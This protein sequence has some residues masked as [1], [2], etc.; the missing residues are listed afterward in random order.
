MAAAPHPRLEVL[1][2]SKTFDSVRVLRDVHIEIAPGEIHGLAGHNGSGKSTLV[3][4]LAG[5]HAPDAG[6]RVRLDGQ[7]LHLP[8]SPAQARAA[9]LGIVH[10]DL[11]LLDE[12]SIADNVCVGGFPVRRWTRRI[13]RGARDRLTEQALAF[14]G[15]P[16]GPS[17][18]VASLPAAHRAA[19]ATARAVRHHRPGSGMLVLD[20]STRTATGP[21]RTHIHAF[22]RRIA[23]EG[24]AVLLVSHSLPELLGTADRVTVL[25]D[26]QVVGAGL[27]TAGLTETQLARLMLG[28]RPVPPTG[29]PARSLPSS[30]DRAPKIR[31]SSLD[32]GRVSGISLTVHR[33]EIVGICGVPG[34]GFEDLPRL[35]AGALPARSGELVI[36]QRRLDLARADVRTCLRAGVALV[37]ECRDRE[38]LAYDVDVLNNICLPSLHSRGRPGILRRMRQRDLCAD[39]LQGFD[40]RPA[41]PERHNVGILSGGNQQKVLLAKWLSAT[42]ELLILHEPTQSVD[43]G[44]RSDILRAI[45]IAAAAS[46]SVLVVSSEPETLAAVCDRV[47]V[48]RP[49]DGRLVQL[50]SPQDAEVILEQLYTTGS[51]AHKAT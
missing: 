11:G 24:S 40:I 16:A 31:L 10:Q 3:K 2:L 51:M 27:L 1:G 46:T 8:V 4:I 17:L 20:E 22:L 19:V 42:P 13:D 30:R 38:G 35:L 9:G 23:Q 43:V 28:Q 25:R 34:S 21:D 7:S 6:A 32:G 29:S 45:R 50:D 33:G 18:R 37:P 41:S 14:L 26:G 49:A 39:A 48:H 36:G 15:V 12:L 47:L 5:V 44:A